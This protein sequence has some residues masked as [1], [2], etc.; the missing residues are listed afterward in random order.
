MTNLP[1]GTNSQ[2]L[3]KPGQ[4][5]AIA[6]MTLI[7]GIINILW[8]LGWTAVAIFSIVPSVFISLLCVPLTILPG[9]LGIFELI[10]AANLLTN[11]PKPVRPNQ[12]IAILEIIC[13]ISGNPYP[14]VVG[15]LALVFYQDESVKTYFE[16]LKALTP[17]A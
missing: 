4:V 7:S 12:T 2:G 17:R 14:L 5:Q 11:P 15:I 8:S 9:I 13:V 16:Q 6:I 3:Q 1:A 10:Y